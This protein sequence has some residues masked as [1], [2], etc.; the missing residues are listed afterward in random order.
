MSKH[1]HTPRHTEYQASW[2][3]ICA[4]DRAEDGDQASVV[5][6]SRSDFFE[7]QNA[8]QLVVGPFLEQQCLQGGRLLQEGGRLHE[9]APDSLRS[10]SAASRCRSARESLVHR[11]FCGDGCSSV[12]RA[13]VKR[14]LLVCSTHA[15]VRTRL[16]QATCEAVAASHT[17]LRSPP[18]PLP[19]H[20]VLHKF[21]DSF[22]TTTQGIADFRAKT[23]R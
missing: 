8:G 2:C 16:R 12:E 6:G 14:Y 21:V 19:S 5:L 7:K 15:T 3:F 10:V 1:Q 17:R 18:K 23:A 9:V 20:P 22:S 11:A 4:R 13:Q